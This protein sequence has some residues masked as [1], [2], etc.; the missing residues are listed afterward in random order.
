MSNNTPGDTTS[1]AT[2]RTKL[3][4][5]R[6]FLAY[7]RTG[8][9]ISVLAKTFK[10][11]YIFLFGIFMIVTSTFQ[12]IVINRNIDT[13]SDRNS[14]IYDNMP[15]LYGVMGLI[16]IYLQYIHVGTGKK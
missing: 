2:K 14:T 12:Y 11:K 9:A 1:L 3:A 13:N 10:K 7:M 6:T 16:V 8:L 15:I 5:Q 4:N